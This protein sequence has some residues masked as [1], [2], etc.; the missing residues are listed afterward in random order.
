[1]PHRKRGA[2]GAKNFSE[3]DGTGRLK[4]GCGQD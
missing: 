2:G 1:V 4:G 3:S